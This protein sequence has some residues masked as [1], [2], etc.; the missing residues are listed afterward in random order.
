MSLSQI[1]HAT[2]DDAT[3]QKVIEFISKNDWKLTEVS[4]S[5]ADI[6]ELKLF[7][8]IK[9]DLTVNDTGDLILQIVIPK[10]SENKH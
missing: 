3:L 2:K 4:S 6:Q 8:K 1:K 5:D 9:E 10:A 7:S